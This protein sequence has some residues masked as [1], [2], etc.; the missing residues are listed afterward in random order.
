[1][2]YLTRAAA[3]RVLASPTRC[4]AVMLRAGMT[5]DPAVTPNPDLDDPLATALEQL[6]LPPADRLSVTDADLARAG[7]NGG[8]RLLDLA[9]I[10]VLEGCVTAVSSSARRKKWGEDETE[11]SSS[12]GADLSK[13]IEIKRAAYRARWLTSRGVAIAPTD[14]A[15]A[16]VFDPTGWVRPGDGVLGWWLP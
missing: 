11:Y 3:D 16:N 9:E 1:V 14:P 2:A 6:G 12:Q 10:A 7:P 5:A 8:P 15:V 13:L 4:R